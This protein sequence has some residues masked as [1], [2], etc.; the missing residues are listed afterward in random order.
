VIPLRSFALGKARLADVLDDDARVAFARS[1]AEQVVAAAG[2]NL[3]VVVSSAPEVCEWAH[4]SGIARIDDPGSLDAAAERGREWVR[5]QG[6]ARVVVAHGDLPLATTF[7]QVA[8]DGATPVAVLVP[9]RHD[10]GTPVLSLPADTPFDFAYGPGS[11]LHHTAE[12]RR[13]GLA[14][15]IARIP[16]LSF[17]VDVA[18][19]LQLLEA[20][21]PERVQ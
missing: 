9:D 11:F 4:A 21:H 3:V 15:R 8:G 17:D 5:A 7:E 10:D 12:A 18:A 20:Q 14:V 1:M 16:E 2:T 6:R 13:R 19:D